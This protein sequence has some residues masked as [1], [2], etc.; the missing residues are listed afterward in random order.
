MRD[1]I[2]NQLVAAGCSGDRQR[3]DQLFEL[4]FEAVY[5][6]TLIRVDGD[7]RRAQPLTRRLL[8]GCVRSAMSR[9]NSRIESKSTNEPRRGVSAR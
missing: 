7:H 1:A 4:W 6:A 5:A 8:I 2:L 9:A 3:F